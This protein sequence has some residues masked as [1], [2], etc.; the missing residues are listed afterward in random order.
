MD[1]KSKNISYKDPYVSLTVLEQIFADR[2]NKS[3]ETGNFLTDNDSPG[4]IGEE[5]GFK[6]ELIK[7]ISPL[8]R[9]VEISYTE[10]VLEALLRKGRVSPESIYRKKRFLLSFVEADSCANISLFLIE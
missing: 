6:V 5:F 9:I 10:Q 2:C 3:L 4:L 8:N 1:Y 7:E